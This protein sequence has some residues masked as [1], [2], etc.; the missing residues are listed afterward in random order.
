MP[1][2]RYATLHANGVLARPDVESECRYCRA[3][4]WTNWHRCRVG[5]HR[6]W[7]Y[8]LEQ[9]NVIYF[10]ALT[11]LVYVHDED[12]CG[13]GR[14]WPRAATERRGDFEPAFVARVYE[15]LIGGG[16]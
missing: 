16:G 2:P 13:A 14:R 9:L 12:A 1:V 11:D 6:C 5:C 10:R 8:V 7:S 3:R 4:H 15:G